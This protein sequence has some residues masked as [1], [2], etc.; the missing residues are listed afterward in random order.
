MNFKLPKREIYRFYYRTQHTTHK[1]GISM[2][3]RRRN[4]MKMDILL[5]E[6]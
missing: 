2:Y 5:A 3:S 1:G 4:Y 6:K